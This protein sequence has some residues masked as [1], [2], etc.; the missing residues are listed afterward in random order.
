[1]RFNPYIVIPLLIIIFTATYYA[2]SDL[3]KHLPKKK[4]SFSPERVDS[5]DVESL[6]SGGGNPDAALAGFDV[7]SFR[8][9]RQYSEEEIMNY[10]SD[11][12][13]QKVQRFLRRHLNTT[14]NLLNE[15]E[16]LV[17]LLIGTVIGAAI[18]FWAMPKAWAVILCSLIGCL[19]PEVYLR[20]LLKQ[21]REEINK[22]SI[23]LTQLV[24]QGMRAS[25][26]IS[27]AFERSAKQL[28]GPIEKEIEV[29]SKFFNSG[30]SFQDSC[31][32]AKRKTASSFLEKIYSVIIMSMET[33]ISPEQLIERLTIIRKNLIIEYYLK[34]AMKAQA[35]GA[36]LAKNILIVIVPALLLLVLKRSPIMLIP[37]IK[38]PIGWAAIAGGLGLYI[39]GIIVSNKIL[40]KLEV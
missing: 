28:H 36:S 11:N 7:G 31:R 19:T 25:V 18:G 40:K 37:L 24:I 2:V 9:Y 6:L 32:E 15:T 23:I 12:P 20:F 14:Y 33:R 39:G 38:E 13:F 30:F 35:G 16:Y 10:S 22:Q 17:L 27:E 4:K 3:R 1:M 8:N 29:L 21:Y 5:L 26:P 34:E